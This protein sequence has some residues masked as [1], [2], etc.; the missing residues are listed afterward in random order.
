MANLNSLFRQFDNEL[1]ISKTKK[2]RMIC[3]RDNLRETITAYFKEN[4]PSYV[5]KFYIQ[6]SYKLTT[7]IRTKEDTCD[8]DDGV[9]FKENPD[10][11]TGTTLQKWVKEAVDGITTVT[12]THKKKCIR[13]DYKAD[14]NIDLPVFVFDETKEL[15]PNLAVKDSGFQKDDP[16]EFVEYFRKTKT[17]QMVRIIKYLKSWCDYK[18][19]D[20]PSGLAMTVLTLDCYQDYDRD[21]IA[22]K[23]TLIEIENKL[24]K[25]FECIMPTTPYDNLFSNYSETKRNNFM[26]NLKAFIEDA[27]KA[28]DEKNI[29]KASR[30]WRNHLGNRFPE[31]DDIDENTNLYS[32]IGTS[33]PYY[34]L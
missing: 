29:L 33:K 2:E 24:K 16:K 13:V 32:T 17:D 7:L 4:H 22:L 3:S 8:L 31:G 25:C 19:Q 5:P 20:M 23:F 21:D 26:N 14:Y 27:R 34:F 10:N 30:F 15:H 12:P 9:Y 1:N 6:G 28:L 18:R 11:V